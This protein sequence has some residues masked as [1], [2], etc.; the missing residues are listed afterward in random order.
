MSSAYSDLDFQALDQLLHRVRFTRGKMP[1][2]AVTSPLSRLGL[3]CY[4]MNCELSQSRTKALYL[5]FGANTSTSIDSGLY[6]GLHPK[7]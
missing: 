4:L 7:A 6:L 1:S 3:E 5:S 2:L